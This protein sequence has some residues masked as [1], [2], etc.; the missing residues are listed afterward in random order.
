MSRRGN[1]GFPGDENGG[2]FFISAIVFGPFLL[3]VRAFQEARRRK[4]FDCWPYRDKSKSD[5]ES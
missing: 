5:L 2:L 3:I 1:R 4:A